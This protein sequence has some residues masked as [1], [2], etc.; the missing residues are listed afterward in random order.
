MA[1]PAVVDIP[2][3]FLAGERNFGEPLILD[4]VHLSRQT[5]GDHALEVELLTLFERQ[6]AH[7]AVRLAD[8]SCPGD[9]RARLELAHMLKGSARSVGALAVAASAEAYETALRHGDEAEA[10]LCDALIVDIESAR[11]AIAELL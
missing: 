4:L 3:E 8:P 1:N 5:F 6:A 11:A 10:R 9:S 7:L 2:S